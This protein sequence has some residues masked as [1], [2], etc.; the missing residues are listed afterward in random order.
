MANLIQ[1]KRASAWNVS[2]DPGATALAEGELAWN[3]QGKKLWMGRR[4]ATTG[5]THELLRVN[6]TLSGTSNEVTVS[7]GTDAWTIGLPN[8]ITISGAAS[9]GS[10]STS[11]AVS[12]GSL[13]TTSSVTCGNDLSVGGDI[14][15]T[16]NL[17][18]N[19][20]TTT[21]NS[22]IVA[23]DDKSFVI[24]D[25]QSAANCDASGYF[26]SDVASLIYEHTGTKLQARIG[27]SLGAFE[28]STI[29]ATSFVGGNVSEWDTAYSQTREW[30]GGSSGL[31]AATG[32]TSLG[33]GA[34]AILS[35][36]N[37]GV[38]SGTDLSVANGGTGSSSASG[39]RTN[40]GLGT[41][42]V[43]NTAAVA[44]GATTTATGDQIYDFVTGSY[45]GD[46]TSV[47]AGS[48]LSGGGTSGSVTLAVDLSELADDT[49]DP[50]G[51]DD[52]VFVTSAGATK[53]Y[54]MADVPLTAF[55]ETGFIQNT[56]TIDGGTF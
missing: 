22:T 44:N 7:E 38:W 23:V 41:A 47:G 33:L 20:T 40:L 11:G 35:T 51:S 46:I 48:G 4:I 13:T 56:S 30:D 24:A 16:G 45:A 19:G 52:M 27:A 1:L 10:V 5:T 29:T 12:S 14:T 39:A 37:N 43:L 21:I 25:G 42:A 54:S 36:V 55:D 31:T 15:V 50:D 26:I 3:N 53:K 49:A 2:E 18:V 32:R 8:A 34:L 17:T 6:K 28:A 9:V